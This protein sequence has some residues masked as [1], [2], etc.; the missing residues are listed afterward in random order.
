MHKKAV[1]MLNHSTRRRLLATTVGT[2]AAATMPVN[3]A[4]AADPW[5]SK[6][7]WVLMP[8]GAGGSMDV[9][10]RLLAPIVSESLGQL[11]VVENR[12]GA[13]G[14][15]AMAAVAAAPAD[16]YTLMFTGSSF[17]TVALLMRNLPFTMDAF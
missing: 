15:L 3:A 5:P 6:P 14:T 11:V 16:G 2:V 13:T 12:P 17:A 4:C 8:F 9:L 10:S 1:E 7:V